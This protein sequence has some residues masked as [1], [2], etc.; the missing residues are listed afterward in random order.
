MVEILYFGINILQTLMAEPYLHHLN[1]MILIN[2]IHEP[3]R[4]VENVNY[5]LI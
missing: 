5:V 3:T 4:I 1:N 2:L